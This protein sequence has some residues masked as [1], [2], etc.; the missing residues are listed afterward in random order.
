MT[1]P[2]A[3]EMLERTTQIVGKRQSP[4]MPQF[5]HL[6]GEKN[7]NKWVDTWEAPKRVFIAIVIISITINIS[8]SYK[9]YSDFF[10]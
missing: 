1:C 5:P 8:I 7:N 2:V 10:Y 4:S 3:L 6:Q 9:Y